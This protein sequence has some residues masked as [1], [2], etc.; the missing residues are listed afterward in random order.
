M[1]INF[2]SWFLSLLVLTSMGSFAVEESQ[3]LEFT[4]NLLLNNSYDCEE[5]S[6]TFYK[7]G[8]FESRNP[9]SENPLYIR[10]TKYGQSK[11]KKGSIVLSPGR[12]E[13][14]LKYAEFAYDFIQ[15]GY[16]PIFII[17]HRGQGLSPRALE[18]TNKGFVAEF[19]HFVDDFEDFVNQVVLTDKKTNREKLYLVGHS[20][21]VAISNIYNQRVGKSNPFKAAGLFGGMIKINLDGNAPYF[22]WAARLVTYKVCN[23]LEGF[24]NLECLGY[25]QKQWLDYDAS[26]RSIDPRDPNPYNMTRSVQRFMFRDFL[27]NEFAPMNANA[28]INNEYESYENWNGLAL[29]GPTTQW[30]WQAIKANMNM[31]KKKEVKKIAIP[32]LMMTGSQDVRAVLKAHKKFCAKVNK[33]AVSC[34]YIQPVGGFHELLLEDDRYRNDAMT[35]LEN[36]FDQY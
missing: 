14:S 33:H 21:G 18:N 24:M 16:S 13:S 3:S 5:G 19:S 6:C 26:S 9:M 30:M 29:G 32:Y 12:T 2:K 20:M 15:K 27:W 11:G 23:G 4:K 36:F 1:S 7:I 22:E 8:K 17:D 28:P 35:R 31:R 25:V 34:R 10:Y